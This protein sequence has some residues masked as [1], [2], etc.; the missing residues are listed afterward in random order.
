MPEPTQ[1]TFLTAAS[2]PSGSAAAAEALLERLLLLG[3]EHVEADVDAAHAVERARRSAHGL[4]EL[5]AD[6]A[7]RGGQRDHHVDRAL[8]GL[9]DRADH[10]ERDDVLAQLGVDYAQ[11]LLD[12]FR[13]AS[14]RLSQS[15][16]PK[17][18][19]PP[20]RARAG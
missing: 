19:T 10:A 1:I 14:D 9:L 16:T 13:W 2:A 18:P 15:A 5:R 17:K 20:R 4:L 8:V 12:L 3:G 11:R 7:A 6:R